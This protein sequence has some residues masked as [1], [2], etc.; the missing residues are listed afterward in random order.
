[1]D[2]QTLKD[3]LERTSKKEDNTNNVSDDGEGMD[4][5]QPKALKKK[6][7]DRKDKDIDNDGD[8][9]KSDEYLHNRR[10]TVSK[11]MSKEDMDHLCN[12]KFH[13]CAVVVEHPEWGVGKPIMG[14]HAEPDDAGNVAWYDVEFAHGIE[15]KVY[16]SGLNIIDEMNHGKKK[17]EAVY[18]D[19]EDENG[20]GNGDADRMKIPMKKKKNGNGNGDVNGKNDNEVE[21]NPKVDNSKKAESKKAAIESLRNKLLGVLEANQTPHKDAAEKPEDNLKGAGAKKMKSDVEAGA[22]MR[23]DDE[24]GHDD[25]SKA[26]RVGPSPKPRPGDNKAGDKNIVNPVKK[27]ELSPVASM[28]RL[29]DAFKMVLDKKED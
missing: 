10:K 26:G 29:T 23:D 14:R 18:S 17:K 16:A 2:L 8:V 15:K 3:I 9:D 22:Q 6:F 1:M 24:K 21:M 20:N 5:V 27:E 12:S 19:D 7:A 4:K 13:V 28:K 11:A 25:A